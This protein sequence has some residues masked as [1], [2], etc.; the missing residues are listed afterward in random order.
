MAK[1]KAV[2]KVNAGDIAANVDPPEEVRHLRDALSKANG[3]LKDYKKAQGSLKTIIADIVERVMIMEPPDI[4][5]EAP[6]TKKVEHPV[7]M[8]LHDT[9]WHMGSCQEKDEIEGFSVFSPEILDKR[10]MR[11]VDK[12]LEWVLLHRASYEV[13]ECRILVTGDLISGDIHRELSVTNEYPVPVQCVEAGKLLAKQISA[14][15]PHF[16]NVVVDFLVADNHSRLTMKPQHNE[17]GYNSFNY[18]IG[19][20][21][22][23]MLLHHSN[24]DF[25]IYPREQQLVVCKNYRYLLMHGHQIR[26]WAGLPYYGMERKAGKEAMKRLRRDKSKFDKIIMGHF[27]H[28]VDHP[29]FRVG[30][31]PQG[32]TAFD[33]SQGRESLPIQSAWFIHPE[34]GEFDLTN[35]TL[36]VE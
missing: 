35:W 3:R 33:H 8:C 27:H 32:T 16:A 14:L 26:G 11:L 34:Y 5:Y 17:G 13:D 4:L 1:R 19:S 31:S 30:G 29:W 18:I 36:L 22:Q 2:R 15:C 7:A 21:A 9:D 12:L 20:I 10:I 6:T 25:N 23:Q 24:V 28:P